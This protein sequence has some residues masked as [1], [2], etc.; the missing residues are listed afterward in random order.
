[1]NGLELGLIPLAGLMWLCTYPSRAI[2]M[3]A[4]GID[5]LPAWAV[6]Y[7]RLAGPA[8]LAALAAVNC[9]ISTDQPPRLTLG[10]VP[11]AVALCALVVART[12]QLLPGVAAAVEAE[13]AAVAA[14][15]K[16]RTDLE[17]AEGARQAAAERAGATASKAAS[18]RGRHE[19]VQARLA[20]EEA[21]GIAKAAKRLGG[22][23]LAEGL[24]VEAGFRVAV[25]AALGEAMRGFVMGREGCWGSTVSAARSCWTAT[26]APAARK[27]VAPAGRPSERRKE[28]LKPV[29]GPSPWPPPTAG[30]S[31]PTRSAWI[32]TGPRRGC[33]HGPCGSRI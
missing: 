22:K 27:R 15:E 18:L 32:R 30:A 4:P 25:E 8:S 6:D 23:P 28:R 13:K 5:R 2:P 10:V 19:A 31:W 11:V 20:E 29:R 33:L 7:L 26:P 12:R 1:V 3:L 9:L 17:S 14:R 16:A 21:R 24:E